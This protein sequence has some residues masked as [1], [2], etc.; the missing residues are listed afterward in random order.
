[1][2]V[3]GINNILGEFGKTGVDNATTKAETN[4]GDHHIAEKTLSNQIGKSLS[5]WL[6]VAPRCGKLFIR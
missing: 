2:N 1:M 3:S 4:Q 6:G 5:H